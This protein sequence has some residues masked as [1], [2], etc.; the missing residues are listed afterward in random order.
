MTVNHNHADLCPHEFV[1]KFKSPVYTYK[2][3][4]KSSINTLPM[5]IHFCCVCPFVLCALCFGRIMSLQ[6]LITCTVADDWCTGMVLGRTVEYKHWSRHRLS[7]V[8][9]EPMYHFSFSQVLSNFLLVCHILQQTQI[10]L[11]YLQKN[12]K[13]EYRLWMFKQGH[14]NWE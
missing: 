5:V 13:Y 7:P 9:S 14:R 6:D 11:I 10:Y 2:N 8:S 3:W 4:S 12:A 1:H